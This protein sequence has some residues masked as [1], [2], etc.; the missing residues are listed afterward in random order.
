MSPTRGETSSATNPTRLWDASQKGLVCEWPQRQSE[1]DV[2]P[3][4]TY[5]WVWRIDAGQD[6]VITGRFLEV[7]RPN[8]IVTVERMEP[9]T[10]ESH[11][12]M[13]F[14]E[15]AGR[16]TVSILIRLPNK[17]A[18]DAMLATGMKDGMDLGYL[19]LDG[20]LKELT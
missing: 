2:R 1:M 7:D 4:G 5:R 9:S 20:L 8:R 19:R 6:V 12:I 10:G 3:G 15:Q 14:T 11:N 18:R 13:T 17:E 16:T